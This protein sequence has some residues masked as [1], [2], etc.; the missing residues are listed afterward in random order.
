MKK[1]KKEATARVELYFGL[2]PASIYEQRIDQMLLKCV[3]GDS[4]Q[5][6]AYC[7]ELMLGRN[8]EAEAINAFLAS[9]HI[10]ED[11]VAWVA[12][13]ASVEGLMFRVK[14]IGGDIQ[15]PG[16]PSDIMYLMER[17]VT[18][19]LPALHKQIIRDTPSLATE[20][21]GMRLWRFSLETVGFH[22]SMAA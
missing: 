19:D 11:M 6:V 8:A 15:T 2:V 5:V 22:L 7:E 12:I 9:A 21:P 10:P 16:L 4:A 1:G 3:Q 18:V 13:N 14:R 20:R 17:S